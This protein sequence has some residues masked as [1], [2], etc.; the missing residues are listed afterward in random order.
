MQILI[1]FD[2]IYYWFT[3]RAVL[4]YKTDGKVLDM[5]S[6]TVPTK[7]QGQGLAR[8]LAEVIETVELLIVLQFYNI[9]IVF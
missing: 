8:L 3:A 9:Y 1:D 6:V 5:Q 2:D 7:Y 4:R